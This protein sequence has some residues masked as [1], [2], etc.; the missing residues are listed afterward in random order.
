MNG[1]PNYLKGYEELWNR[2]PHDANMDQG[3]T[4]IDV[5]YP[6]CCLGLV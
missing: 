5:Y 1:V 3:A 2:N 4:K 6:R